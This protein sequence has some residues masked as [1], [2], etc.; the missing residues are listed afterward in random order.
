MFAAETK[1]GSAVIGRPDRLGGRERAG[2]EALVA[3]DVGREEIG[4][5]A[6]IGELAG[7]EMLHQL[8]HAALVLAV[9]EQRLAGL[10]G[11]R[12]VDVAR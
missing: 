12:H 11:Q 3:V 1:P 10:V 8:A 5:F 4:D 9:D 7:H 6:G 2:L